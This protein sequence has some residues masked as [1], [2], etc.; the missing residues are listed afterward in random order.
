MSDSVVLRWYVVHTHP[1][2]EA[3]ALAN[4]RRQGFEAYLPC[5]RARRRHAGRVHGVSKPLFPRYLFVALDIARQRWRA[6]QSTFGVS[7][8]VGH[9]E[10]PAALPH[11]V[12]EAIRAREDAQGMVQ[13]GSAAAIQPGAKVQVVEGIF[14][15]R[16]GLFESIDDDTRVTVLLG[17]LG[18]ELRVTLPVSSVIAA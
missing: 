7:H 2:G 4:L 13:L 16:F 17:I 12:V 6:I 15:D 8:L 5:Y 10:R 14:A 11:A 18:R 3:R 9:A 1:R